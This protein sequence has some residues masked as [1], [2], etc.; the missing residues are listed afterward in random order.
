MNSKEGKRISLKEG[1]VAVVKVQF[2][3][4]T[5][6]EANTRIITAVQVVLTMHMQTMIFLTKD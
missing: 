5:M 1:K 3:D 4:V 6:Q 2:V